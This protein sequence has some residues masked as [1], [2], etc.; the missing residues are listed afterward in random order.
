ME[1][2]K[3]ARLAGFTRQSLFLN[4]LA[5]LG[6]VKICGSFARGEQNVDSDIDFKIKESREDNIY[7]EPN[8][9]IEQ[10]KQLLDKYEYK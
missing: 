10:V 2:Q 1:E 7:N 5:E 6:I 8:R 4:E 9:Y 3:R